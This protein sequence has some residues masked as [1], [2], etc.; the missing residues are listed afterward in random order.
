MNIN[1]TMKFE[2]TLTL[3]GHELQAARIRVPGRFSQLTS[4]I[5]SDI[6]SRNFLTLSAEV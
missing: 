3:D 6:L 2:W 1:A 4:D 5:L